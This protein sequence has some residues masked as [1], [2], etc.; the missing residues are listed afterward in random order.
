MTDT[1]A[2][3]T[4][5]I[6]LLAIAL[7]GVLLALLTY[8]GIK[9]WS[10]NKTIAKLQNDVASKDKTIEVSKGVYEK[11]ALESENLKALLDRT[12]SEVDSLVKEL[13]KRD[14]DLLTANNLVVYWKQKYDAKG[15]GTQTVI[16]GTPTQP[17]QPAV[18]R[19]KVAFAKDFGYLGV[20][21]YTLTSPPEYWVSIANRRPL[22]LTLV[23]GRLKDGSWKADVTS[24]EDNVG[25]DI[26]I[27]AVDTSLFAPPWYSKIGVGVDLG[28]GAQGF[29]GGVGASYAFG[30]F[31]VGPK[32]WIDI[33]GS[34][35]GVFYGAAIS[36][37]PF[38]GR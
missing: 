29:L 25:V 24:S 10:Y 27:A 3:K 26:S 32:V 28:V 38:A 33:G 36:W 8:G 15:P 11:L 22:K 12:N 18:D 4:N 14:E 19:I 35:V 5:Y 6:K 13:D 37:H 21:G 30:K 16:P 9:Q 31:E 7:F 2:I 34:G 17:G 1:I 20:E 23:V